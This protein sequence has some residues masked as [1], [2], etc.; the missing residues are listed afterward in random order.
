MTKKQKKKKQTKAQP[1]ADQPFFT[2]RLLS[3]L[4]VVSIASGVGTYFYMKPASKPNPHG[5]NPNVIPLRPIPK[6]KYKGY[7]P[8]KVQIYQEE[9]VISYI[10]NKKHQTPIKDCY[11]GY[12]GKFKVNPKGHIVVLTFKVQ[13]SGKVTDLGIV[14]NRTT[15]PV[16]PIL[17]CILKKASKWQFRPHKMKAFTMRFPFFFR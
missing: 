1:E 14:Q 5:N 17:E 8:S 11:F 2:I 16:K 7:K 10:N 9:N 6:S 15:L 13:P 3:I 4:L 12:K